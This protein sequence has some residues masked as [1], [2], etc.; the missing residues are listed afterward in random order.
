MIEIGRSMAAT[1]IDFI[2]F[3]NFSRLFQHLIS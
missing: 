1:V 2:K 3:D